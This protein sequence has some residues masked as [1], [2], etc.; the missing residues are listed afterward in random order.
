MFFS[1]GQLFLHDLVSA[2]LRR[3]AQ[4]E[5]WFLSQTSLQFFASSL[6]LVYDAKAAETNVVNGHYSNG[7]PNGRNCLFDSYVDVRMI[8]FAHVHPA[9]STDDN[10]LIGVRSLIS[11]FKRL[12]SDCYDPSLT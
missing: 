11:Y 1:S 5:S 6:L 4:I 10:Y 12:I 8:D 7:R 9:T 3:L 2:F